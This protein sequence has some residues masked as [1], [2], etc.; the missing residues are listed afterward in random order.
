MKYCCAQLSAYFLNVFKNNNNNKNPVEFE[1]MIIVILPGKKDL[2]GG[3]KRE[4]GRKREL[5]LACKVR[6]DCLKK[7]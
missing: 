4:E 3:G 1:L 7:I 2:R 5:G 6:K